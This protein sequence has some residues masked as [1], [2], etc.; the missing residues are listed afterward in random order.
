[1]TFPDLLSNLLSLPLMWGVALFSIIVHEGAHLIVARLC[2][3]K[4]SEVHVCSGPRWS[5]QWGSTSVKIGL[6]PSSV[7]HIMIPALNSAKHWQQ[8]LI[9][10]AGPL[11]QTAIITPLCLSLY[12]TAP[13]FL[14]YT[15]AAYA[16]H[17]IVVNVNSALSSGQDLYEFGRCVWRAI[18]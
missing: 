17:Y 6:A 13:P 16:I 9:Y 18:R 4:V 1:M 11:A 12:M 3:M 14:G 15:A 2:G 5:W 10:L 8:A 7:G